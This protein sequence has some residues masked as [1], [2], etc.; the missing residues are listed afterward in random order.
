MKRIFTT[1]ILLLACG[2]IFGQVRIYTPE[3]E[4][5]SNG[6]VDRAPDV[7]LDWKAVT[8]GTYDI[9]YQVRLATDP[10]FTNP[11][12]DETITVTSYQTSELYFG[13]EYYW[14][15]RASDGI[16]TSYWSETW[17]FTV[18]DIVELSAPA[19][20]GE[21]K[22]P[23]VDVSWD[24]ISGV[25]YFDIQ[26]DTSFFFT[27][28]NSNTEE[29]LNGVYTINATNAYAVGA[30]GTVIKY[31]GANWTTVDAGIGEDLFDVFFLNENMGWVVGA[32]GTIFKYD[33]TSWTDESFT[34]DVGDLYAV[35][36]LDETNGYVAGVDGIIFQYDGTTWAEAADLGFQVNDLEFIDAD[37]GWAVGA[38]A[39]IYNYDDGTWY[40]QSTGSE[41][42][43]S[44]SIV[45]GINVWAAGDGG[46]IA[47][48]DGIEWTEVETTNNK[49]LNAICM[50][51]ASS[52]YALGKE[53]ILMV[54]NGTSWVQTTS[55]IKA[56][57]FA[58]GIDNDGNGFATGEEGVLLD[59]TGGAFNSPYAHMVTKAAPGSSETIA[60]LPFG[61]YIYWRVRARHA[62]D[63]T[64]W[65][66]AR[67]F[68]T[69]RT[70]TLQNPQNGETE[71]LFVK[72]KWKEITHGVTGYV[73]QTDI[74]ETFT[75]PMEYFVDSGSIIINDFG[76]G[77]TYFWRGKA[78]HT[79]FESDW[80]EPWTFT[81]MDEVLLLS[82][83][84][85]ATDVGELPL[86]DWDSIAGVTKYQVQLS[87]YSN[88]SELFADEIV[89][90][91]Q[92]HYQ[93]IYKLDKETDYFWR[94]RAMTTYTADPDTSGWSE[95]Y[96][97]TT[98]PEVGIE[99]ELFASKVDVYPNPS[100]GNLTINYQSSVASQVRVM[101]MDLVGHTYVDKYINFS[102][103]TQEHT[104]NVSDLANGVYILRLEKGDAVITE[105]LVIDK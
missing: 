7:V 3:M 71:E 41:D 95:T 64:Q 4:A 100:A 27:L 19:D 16:N 1:F 29:D 87:R 96:K 32:D 89:P 43:F 17:S 76:F 10:S 68:Q 12:V 99:D 57:F 6:A 65:S 85:N 101:L 93:V 51:S 79:V 86:L 66:A 73:I 104:L 50:T 53:K 30:S 38:G 61:S 44:V 58:I 83:E 92:H 82:P 52:G 9:T 84:N 11:V 88:F 26:V 54:Y 80:T 20:F 33:G 90:A 98:E 59:F 14:Q 47:N 70:I 102:S 69:L 46:V 63:T 81:T 21:N 37:M 67:S 77:D 25:S 45:S 15:V 75:A 24:D 5:P 22:D 23:A 97:F 49:E 40:D 105:K 62:L 72:L 94:A 28:G 78:L 103:G 39:S 8:S 55:G 56:D 48:Y 36:M 31:D 91:A 60:D 74:D 13:M 35:Y 34:A 42:Y 2:L 18:V